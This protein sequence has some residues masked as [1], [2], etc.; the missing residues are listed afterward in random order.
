MTAR[1]EWGEYSKYHARGIPGAQALAAELDRIVR[2]TGIRSP[3]TTRRGLRARLHYLDSPAGRNALKNAGVRPATLRRWQTGTASPSRRS[4]ERIEEAYRN[5]RS[6]NMLRSGALTKRL[7]QAGAG[8]RLEIYPVDQT[9]V[10]TPHRRDV[11]QRS[12]RV[13]DWHNIVAAWDAGDT[14]RLEAEWDDIITD[15]GSEYDAYAYVS[16]VGIAA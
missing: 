14:T 3:V 5:L 10:R 11:Q 1:D 13:L 8:T 2:E 7:N 15:L 6:H 4:R 12:I 9:A 16:G